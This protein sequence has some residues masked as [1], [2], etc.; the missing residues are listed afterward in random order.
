LA[1]GG[2]FWSKRS[3]EL[4]NPYSPVS[5]AQARETMAAA[6]KPALNWFDTAPPARVVNERG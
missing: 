4:G 6:Q 5:Q 1:N 3:T 2:L